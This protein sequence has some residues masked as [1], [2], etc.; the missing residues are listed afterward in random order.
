MAGESP[1]PLVLLR[2]TGVFRVAQACVNLFPK[3]GGE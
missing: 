3:I 1:P 2:Q